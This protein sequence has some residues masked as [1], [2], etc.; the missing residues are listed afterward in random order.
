MTQ[1]TAIHAMVRKCR[2]GAFPACVGAVAS[3]W[4][5]LAER[6]VTAGY[7]LL[8]PDPVV[9]QLNE[10][11]G[12]RRALFLHDMGT[13]GDVLLRVTGALR[14]NS[15]IFGNAEPA[16]HLHAFPRYANEPEA[17][18]TAQ[19]WALDWTAAPSFDAHTHG[20]LKRRIA[21]RLEATR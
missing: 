5:I 9:G 12:E 3:G 13:L 15:A 20:D 10:L 11:S 4:V 18:R 6:Q 14:I 19:P 8:L 1:D 21:L 17:T 16:L 7:C 2:T